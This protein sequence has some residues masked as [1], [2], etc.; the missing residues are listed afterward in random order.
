MR[1][2]FAM[3]GVA[4]IC[5]V[6]VA[7]QGPP[8]V[9]VVVLLPSATFKAPTAYDVTRAVLP[10]PTPVS[11]QSAAIPT[12]APTPS[13]PSLSF[14]SPTSTST[15]LSCSLSPGSAWRSWHAVPNPRA[16]ETLLMDQNTLW[17]GTA[18]GLFRIDPRIGKY[19]QSLSYET[20][21]KVTFLLPLGQ[22]HL[23]AEGDRG[24]FYYDGQ[25]WNQVQISGLTGNFT[26]LWAMDRDGD[27]WVQSYS[28]SRW[29]PFYR[30]SG[31]VPP[32]DRAWIATN[33]SDPAW[34]NPN[35]C[36]WQTFTNGQ[37]TYR[38]STECQAQNQVPH[39]SESITLRDAP[40]AIDADGSIWWGGVSSW[41][42][43]THTLY[44][45]PGGHAVTFTMPGYYSYGRNYTL[46]PDP[47]HGVWLGDS[48][49]LAY[50]DGESMHWFTL[51]PDPCIVPW[52]QDVTV[53][54]RGTVWLGTADGR[55]LSQAP[56]QTTWTAVPVHEL[57]GRELEQPIYAIAAAPD[58][59][60]WATHGY[61]LFR[62]GG[63]T[64]IGPVQAPEPRCWVSHLVA[65]ADSVWGLGECGIL[66]FIVSNESWATHHPG[67]GRME[68]VVI[69]SDGT[70]YAGGPDG[71]YVYTGSNWRRV[72][73]KDV[74]AAAADRQ[75]GVWIASREQGRLWYYKS[76]QVMPYGQPFGEEALWYLTVD[77]RNRLWAAFS[78]VLLLYNG[79]T[80]RR[81]SPPLWD[82]DRMT[83]SPDGR[84]WVTGRNSWATM[85][86][87]IAVYD[88]A[89]D[90]QP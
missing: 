88:P 53:D 34:K 57:M 50:S 18:I 35:K 51:E 24:Y 23:W 58:G 3:I 85:H 60:L 40:V 33:E 47:V 68:L 5:L 76:G 17:V 48:N 54:L 37:S 10:T 42:V 28:G 79:K 83:S 78:N 80:W 87:T 39:S 9:P 67:G 66:Q 38:S 64:T 44:H 41:S 21:G 1:K 65:G 81:I 43:M 56:G 31:H 72:V 73:Q 75:G 12:P 46:A 63:A 70:V 16:V 52:P 77:N 15:S 36:L 55:I 49:G 7:C 90:K 25:Q 59:D 13:P 20:S 45:D 69:G 22:G 29:Y 86:N 62:V 6:L 30:L 32:K 61:D 14:G 11:P 4:I 27:V 19:T 84:I 8:P 2:L 74:T 82:I 71:L 89:A 26:L